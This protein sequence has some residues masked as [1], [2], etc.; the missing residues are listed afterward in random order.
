MVISEI[1]LSAKNQKFRIKLNSN[2]YYL[3][4]VFLGRWF[5]SI[6]NELDQPLIN[7]LPL[8]TGINLLEQH[9]HLI[10]GSFIV[11]NNNEDESQSF[12]DLGTVIRLYWSDPDE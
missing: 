1:P 6:S 4:F 9:Q 5:I 12:G 11:V 3:K 10:K 2:F 8:V 7:S